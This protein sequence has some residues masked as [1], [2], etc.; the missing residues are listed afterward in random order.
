MIRELVIGASGLVGSHLYRIARRS[1]SAVVGTYWSHPLPGLRFLD[2]RES[3]AVERLLEEFDPEVIY[4]PAAR[5]NVDWV[6]EHP[7]ESRLVNVEGPL[8]LIRL[9]RGSRR[10]L[11]YYSS[12]Y[13]F[14]GEAGPYDESDVPHPINEYGRQKL[15]V[16]RAIQE[17]L[18]LWLIL[19]V[20]VVYGWEQEGKN[21]AQRALR[22]LRAGGTVKAP[23]DQ[24][25]NPTYAS[26]LAEASRELALRGF[27]G[28]FHLAGP[29]RVSR[30]EF[31]REL[32]RVFELNEERVLPVKT[33]ELN[34]KAKRPLNAGMVVTKAQ[35]VLNV[36]LLGYKE[37]LSQM[38]SEVLY[39]DDGCA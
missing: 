8:Q 6:E 9:L 24:L 10:K 38:K 7:A 16:E 14:D 22:V 25:G 5:P 4:L 37:G 28:L 23:T 34:Q 13:V 17:N 32:A 18:D 39:C 27:V 36:R 31:A 35:A 21:F 2:I 26:N 30:Y 3:D 29:E 12:D 11:V 15:A 19:R 33:S 20:T 1:G